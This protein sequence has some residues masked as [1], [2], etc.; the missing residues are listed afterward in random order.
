[1]NDDVPRP[2][3]LIYCRK[4]IDELIAKNNPEIPRRRPG[5]LPAAAPIGTEIP[6]PLDEARAEAGSAAADDF[7][8][9][10]AAD[11]AAIFGTAN[12]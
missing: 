7:L 12:K 3:G 2:A 1:M 4:L 9:G 11:A 10:L 6:E 5:S 8:A